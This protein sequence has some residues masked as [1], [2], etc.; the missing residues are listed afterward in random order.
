[1][2]F[3]TDNQFELP[4]SGQADWDTAM[5][6]NWRIAERGQHITATAGSA[7]SSGQVCT[8]RSG[9]L[10]TPYNVQSAISY[11]HAIALTA[12]SSGAQA[13]FLTVGAVRSMGVWSGFITVGEPVFVAINSPGFLVGSYAG[14]T[15]PVGLAI[16]A[17]AVLF[18]P[19]FPRIL[20]IIETHVATVGPVTTGSFGDFSVPIGRHAT[21]RD[22]TVVT[23]HNRYKVQFW[24]GSS[25]VSSELEYETL[26]RSWSPFSSDITSTFFKD[27]ALFPHD[28]TDSASRWNMYGRISAQSGSGVT[29][30]HFVVTIIAERV[31]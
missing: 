30:A 1:M 20:P 25:R 12:V 3:T 13:Q 2:S 22:L 21:I 16:A 19:G 24:S 15:F 23:S 7:I 11:P 8:V 14:S 5:S 29:S 9:G 26:T 18:R 17:D 31:R 4:P 10:L 6:T 28:G 27:R